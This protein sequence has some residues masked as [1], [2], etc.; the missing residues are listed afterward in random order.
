MVCAV[1]RC[2]ALWSCFSQEWIH[3]LCAGWCGE[4]HRLTA[5]CEM[6]VSNDLLKWFQL[7]GVEDPA[8]WQGAAAFTKCE[9]DAVRAIMRTGRQR[10]RQVI[11]SGLSVLQC[12]PRF[13]CCRRTPSPVRHVDVAKELRL[14]QVD[15]LL[16]R[17]SKLA[18]SCGPRAA[19]RQLE[20]CG[21]SECDR[22]VWVEKARLDAVMGG[23]QKSMKGLKS[24]LACYVSFMSKCAFD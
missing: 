7:D 2:G 4:H 17:S 13:L 1:V 9:L 22:R 10:P 14:G 15:Q 16:P 20:A 21:M 18:D 11:M 12:W 3:I 19:L 8:T 24:A 23:M 5:L 6:I